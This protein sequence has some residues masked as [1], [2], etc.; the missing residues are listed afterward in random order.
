MQADLWKK[1]EELFHAVQAQPPDK[2]AE[3]LNKACPDDPQVRAEVQS[4]LDA[5]PGAASFLNT[6][7]LAS[8]L[9]PGAKL[10]HFEILGMLGR[11]GMGEVC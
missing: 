3:F 9:S 7:P 8:A 5:A 10:G 4:L 2:R 11:G 1:V 6:S